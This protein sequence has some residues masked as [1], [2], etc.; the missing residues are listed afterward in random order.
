[1]DPI[2]GYTE[3]WDAAGEECMAILKNVIAGV[4]PEA[5]VDAVATATFALY[6]TEDG[7]P[8]RLC[9]LCATEVV[10][11]AWTKHLVFLLGDRVGSREFTTECIPVYDILALA[12]LAAAMSTE[13]EAGRTA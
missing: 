3:G 6:V 13:R 9:A 5:D 7:D 4:L 2:S 12:G 11:E 1:M 8:A 10:L